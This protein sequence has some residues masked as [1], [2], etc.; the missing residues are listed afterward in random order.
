MESWKVT[1]F[2]DIGAAFIICRNRRDRDSFTE[3]FEEISR[4]S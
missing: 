1:D 3:T 4:A 2:D